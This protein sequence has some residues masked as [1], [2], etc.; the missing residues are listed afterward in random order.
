MIIVGFKGNEVVYEDDG[1]FFCNGTILKF[2]EIIGECGYFETPIYTDYGDNYSYLKQV[3]D[4]FASTIETN[5]KILIAKTS[6]CFRGENNATFIFYNEEKDIKQ[7]TV[8]NLSSLQEKINIILEF[9]DK[10]LQEEVDDYR[11]KFDGDNYH[12]RELLFFFYDK[13]DEFWDSD[14]ELAQFRETKE[15][16]EEFA[17]NKIVRHSRLQELFG[18]PEADGEYVHDMFYYASRFYPE[19]E[20]EGWDGD[21]VWNTDLA[22][23]IYKWYEEV[24]FD[25]K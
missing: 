16:W 3:N 15:G 4:F 8:Y 11:S 17:K 10:R 22:D 1:I 25:L 7:K 20:L 9:F 13:Y 12:Y 6:Y 5:D 23:M 24:K 21:S 2:S 14:P 18:R 19:Y